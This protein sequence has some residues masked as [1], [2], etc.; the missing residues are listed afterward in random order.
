MIDRNSEFHNSDFEALNPEA[1]EAY[2]GKLRYD[3]LLSLSLSLPLSLPLSSLALVCYA[4]LSSD[5]EIHH[6]NQALIYLYTYLSLLSQQ[7]I[8]LT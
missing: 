4:V 1:T 5:V 8:C 6:Q 3:L 7:T 2:S